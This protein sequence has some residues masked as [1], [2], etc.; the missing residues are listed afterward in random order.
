M[1]VPPTPT[2][3]D[4]QANSPSPH[5]TDINKQAPAKAGFPNEDLGAVE[6]LVLQH[7]RQERDVLLRYLGAWYYLDIIHVVRQANDVY[8]INT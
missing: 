6:G 1:G 3:H 2:E 5:A 8:R 4:M 7:A